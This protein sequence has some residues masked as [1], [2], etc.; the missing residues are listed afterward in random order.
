MQYC[1][2]KLHVTK[3]S[4]FWKARRFERG[5]TYAGRVPRYLDARSVI[6]KNS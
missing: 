2:V 6:K 1:Q 5:K 3:I 4:I